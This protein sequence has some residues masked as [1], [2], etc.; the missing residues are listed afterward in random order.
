M[1]TRVVV[2]GTAT[3]L[4]VGKVSPVVANAGTVGS[5]R[6]PPQAQ[7][8]VVASMPDSSA[9]AAN[10]TG[11][12]GANRLAHS[13]VA[14]PAASHQAFDLKSVQLWPNLL[15]QSAGVSM[16]TVAGREASGLAEG[17]VVCGTGVGTTRSSP[18]RSPFVPE[19]A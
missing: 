13:A 12:A 9:S 7:H 2:G 8:A 11:G 6:P 3:L 16:Q 5:E 19:P 17:S 4:V 1:E 10:A 14:P 18:M 15:L